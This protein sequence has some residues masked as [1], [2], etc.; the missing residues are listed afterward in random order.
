MGE[1]YWEVDAVR[2]FAL[3]GMV[4]FHLVSLMVIFHMSLTL[5]WYYEVC[6]YIH[7]G[8]S[9]FVVVSGVALVLRYGRM[10]GWPKREYHLAI[11]RRGV[12]IFCIGVAVAVVASVAIHFIV[13]DGNY[14]LFN[15][16][17]MTGISMILCIPFL[18]LGKWNFIPAALLIGAGMIIKA[19]HTAPLWMLPLGFL[20]ARMF[21]PRDYF[22]LLP[23]IGVMLLGIAIGSVLYPLGVRRFRMPDAGVIARFFAQVG[24]YLLEI[25]LLHLPIITGVLHLIMIV[26][27]AISMPWGYL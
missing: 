5:D 1:W 21:Y 18:R 27:H 23:W 16:L 11:L 4:V 19:I 22:P 20:P 7:L 15:F 6:R 12:E 13:R 9:V 24:R 3:A 14:M 10:A 8:T 25:Y 2:G 17:Q 26:S